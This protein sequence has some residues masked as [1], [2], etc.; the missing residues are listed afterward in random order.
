M[1][2]DEYLQAILARKAVDTGLFSPVRGVQTVLQPVIQQW[3]GRFLLVGRT[4]WR[5]RYKLRTKG[6]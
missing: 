1:T 4:A 3:A 5:C 2:A 6:R